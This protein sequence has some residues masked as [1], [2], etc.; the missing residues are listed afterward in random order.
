[1]S[2]GQQI[3]PASR[4]IRIL[5]EDAYYIVF[6]KPSGLLV[7]PS[8]KKETNTLIHIVNSVSIISQ[9]ACRLHP[10][11]RLDRETSGAIIFARGKKNQQL[12]MRLFNQGKIQKKYI[13]FV[14][15]R[16][17]PAQGELRSMIKDFHQ[18]KFNRR[19]RARLAITHYRTLEI[20][21]HFSIVEVCPRTG[22]TNQIRIQLSEAGFPLVGERIYAF[23]RDFSLKFRRLALHASALEWRHP[24]NQKLIKVVSPL[25]EDM[26][27]FIS[28]N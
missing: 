17:R 16:L 23:A 21:R 28:R 22:R 9:D 4:P 18:K 12:M 3:I 13:A 7:I 26:V 25:P 10:C 5:F 11:H 27:E 15:G 6:D 24:V 8:P 20:R 1:M 19:V 2:S 14:H